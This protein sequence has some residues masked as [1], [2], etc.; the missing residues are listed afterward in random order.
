MANSGFAQAIASAP[1]EQFLRLERDTGRA[2][3]FADADHFLANLVKAALA[4]SK[5]AE[6]KPRSPS[7][8]NNDTITLTPL[9]SA[10][11]DYVTTTFALSA[12]QARGAWFLPEQGS[13]KVGS[14][15]LPAY[16]RNDPWYAITRSLDEVARTQF[17]SS[18][19]AVATW[20]LL[21]PLFERLMAPVHKRAAGSTGTSEEQTATWAAITESYESLGLNTGAALSVF[22]Y[23]GGWSRLDRAGQARARAGLLDALAN[24][25][26]RQL[27]ERYRAERV[28]TLVAATVKRAK[29]GTP[30]ARKVLTRALQP[31]LC[32]YF[33][34][35]W[36][37]F[38]DYLDMPPNPNEEIVTALPTPKLYVSGATKAATVAA[39]HGLDVDDVHAMLAAFMGQDTS[40]SAVDERVEVMRRWW[41]QF[42]A[43]HAKQTVGMPTL[44]GLVEGGGTFVGR[45]NGPVEPIYRTLLTGDLV[46]DIDQ[47]WDGIVLPRWPETIVSEP[48]PHRLMAET[49]GPAVNFWEGVALTA[50]YVCEGPYSRTSL[51]GLRDY[52]QRDLQALNDAGTPIHLS[53]FEEL[54][55]AA[56]HLG[57]PRYAESE[58]PETDL[59]DVEGIRLSVRITTGHQKRDGFEIL[60][61][62]VTR[63]RQGWTRRYLTDYLHFR[64]NTELIGVARE[65]H[66]LIAVR[67]KPPTFRQFSRLAAHAANH[68]FN[69]DL[70]KLYT[71]IGEKAPAVTNRV[72]LLPTNADDFINAVYI[73]LGGQYYD[74][75]L[76]ISDS[77]AAD[78]Y[79][80]IAR[81]AARSIHYLQIA[82]A[83]GR[84]PDPAEFGIKNYGW[85]W[86][87]GP[88]CGWPLLEQAIDDTIG[89][90]PV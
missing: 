74:D 41:E 3:R 25:D 23:R 72:D 76:R 19:D 77:T 66:R 34:G 40:V 73:A 70:A 88:E 84:R 33:A 59:A 27:A 63:H 87:G 36:L 48:Y 78:H 5:I 67:G 86:A 38:L 51:E 61:N 71:A 57:P 39:D 81:I 64:W 13:L 55:N 54:V 18:A 58:L 20:S 46:G 10:E 52:H 12:Q 29:I 89:G 8:K 83:T 42:D 30:L 4:G 65:L 62:I 37:E 90:L 50:W 17:A 15:N 47:R 69:G 43:L 45:R 1:P 7:D 49:F 80:E 16:I 82:E 11:R 68:W 14:M 85:N 44:W 6:I 53:I 21:L 79:E 26:L 22:A 75:D 60:R 2:E 35:D 24:N 28:Q 32:A 56:Q 31:V 9:G